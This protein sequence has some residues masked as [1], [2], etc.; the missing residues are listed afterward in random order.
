[1]HKNDATL[2]THAIQ[3]KQ[4]EN[5][6]KALEL[7]DQAIKLNG[8]NLHSAY[9]NKG[10]LLRLLN[11]NTGSQDCFKM[12]INV[13]P[14]YFEAWSNWGD[15]LCKIHNYSGA[16]EMF[17]K[18]QRLNSKEINPKLGIAY[19]L[20]RLGNSSK[21]CEILNPLLAESQNSELQSLI[22]SEFGLALLQTN[23]LHEA[24]VNFTKAYELNNNDY[25]SCY[26]IG[27]I[28]DMLKQYDEA[29]IFYDK[30]IS[31][32]PTESKA[33]QGKACTY[34]HTKRYH[35]ALGLILKAVELNP[36]N[37]EG[38]YNLACVYAGLNQEDKTL[39][40][41]KKTIALAPQEIGIQN[42]ILNDPDFSKFYSKIVDMINTL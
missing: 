35:N 41:I 30:A 9:Y 20:N 21:A 24:L 22:F 39:D 15:L 26:N 10:V 37:F 13:K 28:S 23:Q 8:P 17:K 2:I 32:N 42:Y 27:F 6:E 14:D 7:Y 29:L 34:I 4:Q 12:A 33:Y 25:Q 11:N 1:M 36:N 40:A 31:I 5:Y 3:Q 19:C 38:Y 16:L 18:A